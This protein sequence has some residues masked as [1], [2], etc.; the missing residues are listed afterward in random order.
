MHILMTTGFLVSHTGSEEVIRDLSHG[1]LRRNHAVT[2]FSP[3]IRGDTMTGVWSD[4]IAITDD[5]TQVETPDVIHA[6]HGAAFLKA[7]QKFPMVPMVQFIHDVSH[8]TDEPI[9]L[10]SIVKYVAVDHRRAQRAIAAGISR[11]R[12][13]VVPNA[14]DL[15]RF[16]EKALH[17]RISRVLAVSKYH[18]SFLRQVQQALKGRDVEL[19]FVGRANFRADFGE[20]LQNYD[21]LIG[22]GRCALEAAAVGL[23]VVVCDER[24][25]A[26]PLSRASW[27]GYRAGN[28]GQP[29]F[30]RPTNVAAIRQGLDQLDPIEASILRP[31]VRKDVGLEAQIDVIEEI[32]RGAVAAQPSRRSA[33]S[34]VKDIVG[35]MLRVHELAARLIPEDVRSVLQARNA[36]DLHEAR[37]ELAAVQAELDVTRARLN[38]LQ[39]AVGVRP[40]ARR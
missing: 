25:F 38:K 2:V 10:P 33:P 15:A 12:V 6:Q 14:V 36:A 11:D 16:P 22:S 4:Q 26:G 30:I 40:V 13:A 24:G 18:H 32:Y 28:F 31:G 35:D 29:C 3:R 7:W 9:R 5:I 27:P 20:L 8:V 17:T 39:Q 23:S 21:L 34:V 37:R 19:D 1:L